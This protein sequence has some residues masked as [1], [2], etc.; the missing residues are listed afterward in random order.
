M[1][2]LLALGSS[3]WPLNLTVNTGASIPVERRAFPEIFLSNFERAGLLSLE[4]DSHP[5]QGR[6]ELKVLESLDLS[7]KMLGLSEISGVRKGS[8]YYCLPRAC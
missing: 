2:V 8:N 4:V 7:L 3:R 1:S 5:S 6:V